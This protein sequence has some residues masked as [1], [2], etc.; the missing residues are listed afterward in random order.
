MNKF[1]HFIVFT[2]LASLASCASVTGGP[3]AKGSSLQEDRPYEYEIRYEDSARTE[4]IE[5]SNDSFRTYHPTGNFSG[6]RFGRIFSEKVLPESLDGDVIY[7]VKKCDDNEHVCAFFEFSVLAVPERYGQQ[8]GGLS[9]TTMYLVA[10]ANL[11]VEDCLRSDQDVCDAVLMSSDCQMAFIN[12]LNE[13]SCENP[14][15]VTNGDEVKKHYMTYFIYNEDFG[16]TALGFSDT[17]AKS[18][19]EML[20]IASEYILKG[21][22]GFLFDRGLLLRRRHELQVLEKKLEQCGE[23]ISYEACVGGK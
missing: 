14:T 1:C 3:S 9:S 6:V 20:A 15:T 18:K 2:C 16:V 5:F 22:V 4:Y 7:P 21:E 12:S 10:G 23:N 8:G 17:P 11:K 13:R 19:A